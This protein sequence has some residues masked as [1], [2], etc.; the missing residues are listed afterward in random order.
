M[1]DPDKVTWVRHRGY[2]QPFPQVAYLR[3]GKDVM[4]NLRGVDY[5]ADE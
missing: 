1:G 3:G 2:V 5:E 4:L